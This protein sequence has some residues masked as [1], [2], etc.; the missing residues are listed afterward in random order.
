MTPR[1]GWAICDM[2]RRL[3][4]AWPRHGLDRSVI[5]D[6]ST[7]HAP[8][9]LAV[10]EH[11]IEVAEKPYAM[12]HGLEPAVGPGSVQR[13]DAVPAR[14]GAGR[15]PAGRHTI[16]VKM[17]ARP[18]RR[19]RAIGEMTRH[20]F[21]R[22]LQG[23]L[24]IVRLPPGSTMTIQRDSRA[25]GSRIASLQSTP[26]SASRSSAQALSASSQKG[27]RVRPAPRAARSCRRRRRRRW[28]PARRAFSRW[29][30]TMSGRPVGE[31]GRFRPCSRWTHSRWRSGAE[32]IPANRKVPARGAQPASGRPCWASS[33][34]RP[35]P[36]A[37]RH[38]CTP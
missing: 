14:Q 17:R 11:R 32:P 35:R 5:F 10:K 3:R 4:A 2:D 37:Q 36:P 16:P 19:G 20:K 33:R 18:E 21:Q 6:R 24:M 31:R 30:A 12:V 27:S 9:R 28:P 15:L 26:R 34:A 1:S 23:S 22:H 13:K 38:V 8:R 29:T 7:Q 25:P